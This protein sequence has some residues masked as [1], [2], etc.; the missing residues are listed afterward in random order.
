[1]ENEQIT[2]ALYTAFKSAVTDLRKKHHER[3]YYYVFVSD[4]PWCPYLSACS[5]E[6]YERLLA[7]EEDDEE[8]DEGWRKWDYCDSE[9]CV[10]GYE[11]Y[12][13]EAA[14]LLAERAEGMDDDE[15]YGDEWETR[16]ASMEEALRRLDSEG[17]FG[18]GENRNAVV[19]NAECVPPSY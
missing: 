4:S 15:L 12:F 11:E 7:S 1:M 10:Y 19:I 3:F 6:S 8:D 18:T 9:Y 13:G 14:K 5:Y 2:S 16:L 17:F